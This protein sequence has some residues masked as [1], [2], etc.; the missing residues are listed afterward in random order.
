MSLRTAAVV[1]VALLLISAVASAQKGAAVAAS[2]SSS[3]NP[4]RVV[5]V[6]GRGEASARPDQAVV[7]VGVETQA[8]TAAAALAEN[9]RKMTALV[10]AV[11][12][13]GVAERDVQTTSFQVFPYWAESKQGGE[14]RV[15][16]YRVSNEVTVRSKNVAGLGAL[17]DKLVSVGA[18]QVRGVSFEIAEDGPLKDEARKRAMQDAER[19]ARQLAGLAGAEL[20]PVHEI[21]ETVVGGGPVHPTRMMMAE[22]KQAVPVEAGESVVGV[23]VEVVWA[24]R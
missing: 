11:K 16:G 23:D 5:A 3:S 12:Q 22:A 10:A 18:N 24:L 4:P 13:A 1:V 21:R 2:P 7:M 20:G 9:T 8:P 19:K 17:L 15:A 6:S 14:P